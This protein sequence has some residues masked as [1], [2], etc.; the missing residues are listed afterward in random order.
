MTPA[1]VDELVALYQR[2]SAQLSHARGYFEYIDRPGSFSHARDGRVDSGE[3]GY[4][5]EHTVST[6]RL[7]LLERIFRRF[8]PDRADDDVS[9]RQRSLRE[10][11][12]VM[13]FEPEKTAKLL[14]MLR[15]VV[16]GLRG[17]SGRA[18]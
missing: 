15:G 11:A 6:V 18:A 5:E 1:E 3:I 4:V 14:A 12:T 13:L 10:S 16:D 8:A 7:Q 9:G 2:T 17:R